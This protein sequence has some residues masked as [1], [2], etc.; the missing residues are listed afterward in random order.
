MFYQGIKHETGFTE[1]S[2]PD[3]STLCE[4]VNQC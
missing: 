1:G 2:I 3:Q 4:Q